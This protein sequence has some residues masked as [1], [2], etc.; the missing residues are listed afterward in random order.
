MALARAEGIH[1]LALL[2]LVHFQH[3]GF[4]DLHHTPIAPPPLSPHYILHMPQYETC[5]GKPPLP[6]SQ[7]PTM[8]DH[9]LLA[10]N[11]ALTLQSQAASP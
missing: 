6:Q 7:D 11:D 9:T 3:T 10:P 5:Y 8:I 4:T 1:H 2:L